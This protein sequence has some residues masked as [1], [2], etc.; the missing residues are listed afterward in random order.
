MNATVTAPSTRNVLRVW[1]AASD[2]DIA[3]GRSWYASA[4]DVASELDPED[5]ARA[6]A[7][8][9][10]LSPM[11]DWSRNVFLAREAYRMAE[12]G[13][14]MDD[15][16]AT[17]PTMRR[18]AAKAAAIVLGAD[19]A[20]V[21]SGPKVTPFWQR[22][23]D[24]GRATGIGSV[25]VDRHAFDISV[26]RVTDDKTRGAF[27]ARKGGT[28]TV[29]ACYVRA[30]RIASR[31]FGATITPAELQAITWTTW[32]RTSAHHMARAA[33]RRDVADGNAAA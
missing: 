18:N 29:Q 28:S 26:G 1:R 13:A 2:E 19:P 31:E 11:T 17:L 21:V 12:E 27:L 23:A 33:H 7:V 3:S 20:S 25:V 22:I 24:A 16:A 32:R 30:A 5:P 14:T 8:L 9:A 10:V 15:I 6:A 4:R